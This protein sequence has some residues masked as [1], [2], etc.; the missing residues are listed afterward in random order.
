MKKLNAVFFAV[1]LAAMTL[2]GCGTS[3]EAAGD[4]NTVENVT[5][6]EVLIDT[7][8]EAGEPV[9]QVTVRVGAMS[10][11]TAMGLVKLMSDAEAGT[12]QN[13][14]EFADLA[15]EASAFVTPI[16]QGELDIAAVPANLAAVLYNNTEGGVQILAV[17]NLGVLDIVERGD[18]VQQIADLK[19]KTIY[20]TGQGATPEYTLRYILQENGIDPDADVTI[21]WCSDTTEAL[22]YI[23]ADDEAIAMLPQPF[24]TAACAQVED[25]RIAIDLND[26]WAEVAEDS[27]IITGVIVVRREFAQEHPEAVETFLNEYEASMAY[28]ESNVAETAALIEQYGIVGKAAVAEKALPSCHLNFLKGSDMKSVVAAYLEMLY[29]Q[30]P[31]SVGGSVPGDD[32]YYGL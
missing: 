11:P 7:E 15:T 22:S 32:F 8:E 21:Q 30:N 18:T 19:G 28:T 24:V 31:A 16:A 14:Y 23:S 13:V 1:L 2:T 26:A 4:G 9:E 25:L 6:Q 27:N 10:G 17:N 29:E 20:A 3:P 5:E 12:T